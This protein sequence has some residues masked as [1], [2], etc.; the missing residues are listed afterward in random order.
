MTGLRIR[1]SQPGDLA[2]IP[3]IERA[4]S[5]LFPSGRIPDADETTPMSDLIE[6]HKAGWLWIAE[7]RAGE[8]ARIA[9]FA[10]AEPMAGDLYLREMDVH[11]RY[12]RQGVGRTLLRAVCSSSA[13]EGFQGTSL[14]TF[15]DLPWNAPFY[16]TEG[17]SAL[18]PEP[19]SPL[20]REIDVQTRAGMTSRIAMR[21]PRIQPA[22][23]ADSDATPFAPGLTTRPA[24]PDDVPW[25][26]A[27]R[28]STMHRHLNR[29]G[30]GLSDAEDHARVM[31]RFDAI[32]IL[33]INGAAVGMT[34]VDRTARPWQLVQI[35]IRPEF[36][37]AGLGTRALRSLLRE[38]RG[39]R[40]W[41]TLSVLKGNPAQHLYARLGF[42]IVGE[43]ERSLRMACDPTRHSGQVFARADGVA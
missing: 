28:R 20:A 18:T 12:A 8:T 25:L 42:V 36:Q 14:T 3:P 38:V 33:S 40:Q 7:H 35:Q 27:L 31:D 16:A 2:H 41:L 26:L 9:G 24:R 43:R 6:A 10:L 1:L 11:P 17:F 19:G 30:F 15:S 13:A 4:A 39:A 22:P 29:A 37:G 32:A 5:N 34:K 21:R 23:A